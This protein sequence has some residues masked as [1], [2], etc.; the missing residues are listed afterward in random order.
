MLQWLIWAYIFSYYWRCIFSI[1]SWQW[2]CWV[3]GID[4]W[5]DGWM[6]GQTDRHWYSQILSFSQVLYQLVF[7][8]VYEC[9]CFPRAFLLV[10]LIEW[11]ALKNFCQSVR[12]EKNLRMVLCFCNY[13]W[14]STSFQMITGVL[15]YLLVNYICIFLAFFYMRFLICVVQFLRFFCILGILGLYWS[16]LLPVSFSSSVFFNYSKVFYFYLVKVLLHL[17]FESQFKCLLISRM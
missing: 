6:D 11:V 10:S 14:D 1:N 13:E 17:G 2:Y 12:W 15:I 9:A 5:I 7:S 8:P 4:G 16:S 3:K